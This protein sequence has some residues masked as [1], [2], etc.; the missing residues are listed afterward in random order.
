VVTGEPVTDRIDGTVSATLVTVPPPPPPE[1]LAAAVIKPFE[2]TVILALVKLPTLEFTVAR[3]KTFEPEVAPSPEISEAVN[4]EPLPLTIPV[5]SP[6]LDKTE[7][8]EKKAKPPEVPE[9]LRFSVPAV[10]IGEPVTV[11]MPEGEVL[12]TV[13]ATLVT[14]PPAPPEPLEAAVMRPL[15]LT[16]MFALVK[17]PTLLLTVANVRTFEPL[18]VASPETSDAEKPEPLPRTIPV[19]AA[20]L[21]RTELLEKNG[22]PPEVP[23]KLMLRLPSEVTGDPVTVKIPE[24]DVLLTVRPTLVTVPDPPPPPEPLAAAVIK[25]L[26]LTVMLALTKEPML[27][28]TLAKIRRLEPLVVASP[29]ISEAVKPEPEPRTIPTRDPELDRTELVEKKGRLPGVPAKF[30]FRAP[31]EVIGDP[32]T[33]KIPDGDVL[34]MVKATLVSVPLPPPPPPPLKPVPGG[35]RGMIV[36]TFRGF[37]VA[38]S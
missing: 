22:S 23:A 2:L 34:F 17:E 27:L 10:V 16:V 21:D 14:V 38:V 1:P 20:V 31:D 36:A 35:K 37:G 11:K 5:S 24:G 8:L 4:P 13:S 30:M 19:R 32:V 33:V 7:L 6:E 12:L 25:P 3:V 15:A 9:R 28:L 26:E 18:V 29:E